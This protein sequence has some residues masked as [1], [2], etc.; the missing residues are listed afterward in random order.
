[1]I[2]Y[3]Q[4][5]AQE[6]QQ[7]DPS[8]TATGEV[9]AFLFEAHRVF[10]ADELAQLVWDWQ[11]VP[12]SVGMFRFHYSEGGSYQ[13]QSLGAEQ[14]LQLSNETGM[15]RTSCRLQLFNCQASKL[16]IV[17]VTGLGHFFRAANSQYSRALQCSSEPIALRDTNYTELY[18]HGSAVF[19]LPLFLAEA[20]AVMFHV[21]DRPAL[22]TMAEMP[23]AGLLR[24]W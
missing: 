24:P 13:L 14:H 5:K 15:Q 4:N 22:S 9:R 2:F 7:M 8:C 20:T 1:M 17:K 18:M 6:I 21:V 10:D 3:L 23:T 12:S 11:H 16:Q 19:T